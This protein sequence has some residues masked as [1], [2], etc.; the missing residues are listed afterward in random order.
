MRQTKVFAWVLFLGVL[1]LGWKTASGQE[2]TTETCMECHSDSSLVKTDEQGHKISLF[3]SL[4][5]LEHSIH[6]GLE[7]TDC[8][9]DIN[10]IPHPE[11]LQPVNCGSCHEEQ[12]SQCQQG[13]HGSLHKAGDKD[14][15]CCSDCHGTHNILP[16]SDPQS[17]TNPLNQP[18]TC[19]KCHADPE[20]ARRHNLP[21]VLPPKAYE[22]SIH[23]KAL[24]RGITNAPSCS[25]CHSI[26]GAH[27]ILPMSDPASPVNR[28]NVAKTCGR[29]HTK[30]TQT[31]LGSV[32]GV[33]LREGI[34]QAP[35]CT[36]CHG[37]HGIQSPQEPSAPTSPQNV[38]QQVCAPCHN[39]IIMNEKYGLPPD[40]VRTYESSYHGLAVKRGSKEAAN[41]TSCHGV[42]DIYRQSDPRSRINP[43]NLDK[44][45]GTCHPGASKQ[46]TH[47][48]V[49]AY[50]SK[51][52]Y[53][54][55]TFIK[56]AYILLI[57][58]VIGGMLIHNLIVFFF[59]VREKYLWMKRETTVERFDRGMV[60][61]HL[62]LLVSFTTLVITGFALKFPDVLV[63]KLL[64]R[65][66]M[67][68]AVRSLIHRIAGTVLLATAMYHLFWMFFSRRGRVE[69]WEMLPRMQDITDL[70]ETLSYYLR[71][72]RKKPQYDKYNYIE[73][74]EYWALVWGTA[75]MG[76]TGLI[77]WF[78]VEAASLIGPWAYPIA[79]IIH[80]YEAILATLAI[81]VWHFFWVI[82]YP[83]EYP[84]SF[85]CLNG[86]VPMEE[87][88]KHRPKWLAKLTREREM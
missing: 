40:R 23:A 33:A 35:T 82:F 77:M 15:A 68:E 51:V 60:I 28:K 76:I 46:F 42:H 10:E 27:K 55:A 43:K 80:F 71:L 56:Q 32:H 52:E 67:D 13:I 78:P 25:D 5:Q 22:N 4:K 75:V 49:H 48:K 29:C 34:D 31:Y 87:V 64:L 88:E 47:T 58:L 37:E 16:S 79:E 63:F 12:M 3:V 21:R 61:Q 6:G 70:R 66:G 62:L 50:R 73:K 83:E 18:K 24:R 17:L 84:L 45:C 44:T 72:S 11:K 20:F 57:V 2:I 59:Y 81:L 54:A 39:S 38:S 30:I 86:R 1:I 26:E 41:C 7:C 36:D 9:Q 14:A 8:H 19:G 85:V 69:L 65:I 53:R 74:A